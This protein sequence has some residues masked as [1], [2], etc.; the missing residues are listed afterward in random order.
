MKVSHERLLMLIAAAC[1]FVAAL[2]VAAG[3]PL[4]SPWAWAFGG[5]AAWCLAGIA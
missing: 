4:G 1:F 5:F 3:L 2:I